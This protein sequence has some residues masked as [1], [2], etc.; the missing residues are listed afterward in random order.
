MK[1]WKPALLALALSVSAVQAEEMSAEAS[2]AMTARVGAFEETLAAG[3]MGAIFDFMPP[4]VLA[5]L[6]TQAGISEDQLIE[7]SKAQIA[8]AMESVT[9]DSYVM[10]LDAATYQM[11]PDGSRGY[12]LIPTETMMSVEGVGKMKATSQTLS[13]ED[14]GEWYVARV[15]DPGQAQLLAT[16]YPEFAGIDFPAGT[17][18]PVE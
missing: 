15:D 2:E 6:A 4:K 3:D 13:F 7:A 5:M 1:F 18:E 10:D 12:A 11:T 8:A 14:E 17:M 9:I 16:A